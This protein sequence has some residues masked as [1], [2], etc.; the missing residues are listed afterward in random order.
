MG[1]GR[2][3][4]LSLGGSWRGERPEMD[5]CFHGNPGRRRFWIPCPGCCKW[6]GIYI[7]ILLHTSQVPHRAEE[8]RRKGRIRGRTL[9]WTSPMPR[10]EG[11]SAPQ[12]SAVSGGHLQQSEK[13]R[14]VHL[15]WNLRFKNRGER[16]R[17]L[18]EEGREE[19]RGRGTV[20]IDLSSAPRQDPS[21]RL[22]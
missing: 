13:L 11:S 18:A 20:V 15:T 16:G 3:A 2:F 10:R 9:A 14:G 1:W 5:C 21:P 4:C 8:K 19:R 7:H 12:A 17:F 6:D 22:H